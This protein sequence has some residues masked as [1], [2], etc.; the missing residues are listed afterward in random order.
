[1]ALLTV[2]ILLTAGCASQAGR[3]QKLPSLPDSLPSAA[4]PTEYKVDPYIAAAQRLQAEGRKEASIQLMNWAEGWAISVGERPRQVFPESPSWR[5]WPPVAEVSLPRKLDEM[6]E[7]KIY[8]LCRMLF[9]A[10]PRSRF[11]P[12]SLGAPSF[13]GKQGPTRV[14]TNGFGSFDF[15]LWPL[16]PIEIVDGELCD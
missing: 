12:P 13:L 7:D 1:M 15:P 16:Y 3:D 10:R 2:S 11:D 9:V 5:Q 8:V 14:L 4:F 6:D